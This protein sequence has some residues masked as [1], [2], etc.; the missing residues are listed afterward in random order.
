MKI[1]MFTAD[2]GMALSAW[3]VAA[4]RIF[5]SGLVLLPF[6]FNAWKNIPR[7]KRG[8]VLLSGWLGSF[9]PAIL[10][11]LAESRIDSSL[12]GTLNAITPLSTIFIGWGLYRISVGASRFLGIMVGLSGCIL[13]FVNK[14]TGTDS[15]PLFASFVVVA[16]LC[17]GWNVHIVRRHLT[18]IGSLHIATMAFVGLVPFS[19]ILLWYTGFFALPLGQP[20]YLKATLA[21]TALGMVGTAFAS[22]LFYKLVKM[23]GALFASLVTYG[24]PFIAIGWGAV[25]GETITLLQ[26]AA[27][28]II[29]AGVYLANKEW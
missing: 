25:Y 7:Q 13:L 15:H 27:L 6:A 11:C 4:L 8:I 10:F 12:A 5:S 2:G 1:G 29:L 18:G 22:V 24:I 17:Y 23:A 26:I 16:T 3:Q 20:L 9:I 19:F 28:A 14:A 21:G